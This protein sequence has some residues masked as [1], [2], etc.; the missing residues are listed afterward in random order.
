MIN[1]ISSNATAYSAASFWIAFGKKS[2]VEIL[3][4]MQCR[5]LE[6]ATRSDMSR[7]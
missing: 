3:F 4:K 6:M 7:E 1:T 5:A 2:F